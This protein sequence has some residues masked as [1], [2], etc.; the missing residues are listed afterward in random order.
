MG[1][2]FRQNGESLQPGRQRIPDNDNNEGSQAPIPSP[3]KLFTA[4][5]SSMGKCNKSNGKHGR[6]VGSVA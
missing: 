3:A 4:Q 6:Q 2:D 1:F 5:G